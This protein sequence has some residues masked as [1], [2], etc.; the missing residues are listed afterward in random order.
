MN[1]ST[2]PFYGWYIVAAC[3]VISL[4]VSGFITA[5]STAFATS[6]M[7]DL[8]WKRSD[9]GRAYAMAMPPL[10]FLS[11][12]IGWLVDKHGSRKL[13]LAGCLAAGAG[14][15]LFVGISQPWHFSLLIFLVMAG[16]SAACGIPMDALMLR[17]FNR[18]RGLAIAVASVGTSI[19]MGIMGNAA[20]YFWQ[21]VAGK[22]RDDFPWQGL[23]LFVGAAALIITIPLI[24]RF[25]KDRPS[26]MGLQPDGIESGKEMTTEPIGHT[27]TEAFHTRTFWLIAGGLFLSS[28]VSPSIG[29]YWLRYLTASPE[30]S[31][32]ALII[33]YQIAA[34]LAVPGAIALGLIADRWDARRAFVFGISVVATGIVLL[35]VSS[36][37]FVAGLFVLVFGISSKSLF[38]LSPLIIA[39]SHG[40]R[41]FGIIWAILGLISGFGGTASLGL[42][43][44]FFEYYPGVQEGSDP[45]FLFL[46]LIPVALLSAFCI[47]KAK[48][49][50]PNREG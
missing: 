15:I 38:V 25:I 33:L 46:I 42:S 10:F 22:S 36:N 50:N 30:H 26:E 39:D 45:R 35:V 29:M 44:L 16:I 31:P 41:R 18:R 5:N 21:D 34:V 13:M 27:L 48:P 40:L 49:L 20:P 32:S 7:S 9:F 8:E 1:N 3:F 14:T 2:K 24:L 6:L 28:S 23:A 17:W 37:I 4:L 47:Y 43:A 19:G 11:L 12:L